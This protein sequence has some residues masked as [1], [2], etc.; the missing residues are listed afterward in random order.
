MFSLLDLRIDLWA[1][2]GVLSDKYSKRLVVQ[3]TRLLMEKELRFSHEVPSGLE[4]KKC[5]EEP[6]GLRENG[7]IKKLGGIVRLKT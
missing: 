4:R 6:S 5:H 7:A 1:R 2:V 3:G